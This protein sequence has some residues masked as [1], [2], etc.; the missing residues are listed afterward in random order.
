M[1]KHNWLAYKLHRA[2]QKLFFLKDLPLKEIIGIKT[3]YESLTVSIRR[4]SKRDPWVQMKIFSCRLKGKEKNTSQT[5]L[6]I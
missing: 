2:G 5:T 1:I 4:E 6:A 3:L